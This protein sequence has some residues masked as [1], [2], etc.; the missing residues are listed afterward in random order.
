MPVAAQIKFEMDGPEFEEGIP[1]LKLTEALREFHSTVDKGYVSIIGKER[2][3]R[4]DRSV[5]KL[6]ATRVFSGSFHSEIQIIVPAAP[7]VLGFA[8]GLTPSQVWE[9]AKGA[10][11]FLKAVASMRREGNEPSIEIMG[12]NDPTRMLVLGNGN[13]IEVNHVVYNAAGEGERHIKS[14]AKLVD[15]K[16]ISTLSALDGRSEGIELHPADND[17]FNPTTVVEDSPLQLSAK[18]FRLDVVSRSGRLK[19]VE[20]RGI[21]EYPF[22]IIG[23]QKLHPYILALEQ[24]MSYLRVLREVVRHPTGLDIVHGFH[25]LSI[26]E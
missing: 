4:L 8:A 5:Y 23:H 6:T 21:V 16:H 3:S 18:I 24:E 14:L 20:P 2:V 26:A 10:F 7:L 9:V 11:N 15:G 1:V 13:K 19:M 25:L 12:S 17:L 22:K